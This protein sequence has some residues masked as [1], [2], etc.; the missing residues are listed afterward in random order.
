MTTAVNNRV[1]LLWWDNTNGNISTCCISN[2]NKLLLCF[3]HIIVWI[4]NHQIFMCDT[5]TWLV[6]WE[7][8]CTCVWS[9]QTRIMSEQG[10]IRWIKHE[11]MCEIV[12]FMKWFFVWIE[13][14]LEKLAKLLWF[15]W[16][17]VKTKS[18]IK[19]NQCNFFLRVEST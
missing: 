3:V 12:Y 8:I 5:C 4:N 19:I 15:V 16:L 10:K 14:E 11:V 9:S 18:E 6:M 2:I 13:W 17:N 7:Y 1:G